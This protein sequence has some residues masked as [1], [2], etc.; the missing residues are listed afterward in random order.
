MGRRPDSDIDIKGS[1]S[2]ELIKNHQHT[3]SAEI[4]AY[5]EIMSNAYSMKN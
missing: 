2:K 5:S 1:I 4:R 3:I